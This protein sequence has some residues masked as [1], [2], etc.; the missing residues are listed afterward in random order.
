MK[1]SKGFFGRS[2]KSL[3][4]TLLVLLIVLILGI[5]LGVK[6]GDMSLRDFADRWSGSVKEHKFSFVGNYFKGKK[7]DPK[8]IFLI[9]KKE[10]WSKIE[11][12][13]TIAM[14]VG[15]KWRED[16]RNPGYAKGVLKYEGKEN[17]IKVSLKGGQQDHWG[18][19]DKWSL[20][21]K[22]KEKY[23]F[24]GMKNFS[25]QDLR[26]RSYLNGWLFN[27]LLG[28]LGLIKL[29]FD[30]IEVQING[31]NL[32]IY[33][34]EENMGSNLIEFN[35]LPAGPIVNFNTDMMFGKGSVS[36][37]HYSQS[38]NIDLYESKTVINYE[39]QLMLFNK[40]KTLL[41][42]FRKG[43]F[44]ASQVFD[45]DKMAN[46]YALCDLMGYHH[47]LA[48]YNCKFYFNPVTSRLEPIG[49]DNQDIL[50]LSDSEIVGAGK[51]VGDSGSWIGF[52]QQMLK[53]P[54]F[55]KAYV[56]SLN[57]ISK[58]EFLDS[59]YDLIAEEMEAKMMIIH[60]GYPEYHFDKGMI[61]YDNQKVIRQFINPQNAI[62]AYF[63][64]NGIFNDTIFLDIAN[65]SKMPL[66]IE[67]VTNGSIDYLPVKGYLMQP[68][69]KHAYNEYALPFVSSSI[70]NSKNIKV[71]KLK[72]Y[73]H[74]LGSE[75]INQVEVY[76]WKNRNQEY[77]ENDA[78][79]SKG[80]TQEFKFIQ[81]DEENKVFVINKGSHFI[82]SELIFPKGYQV[83]VEKGVNMNLRNHAKIISYSPVL[84][85]GNEEDPI[86]FYSSDS[87]GQG[88]VVYHC[89]EASEFSYVNF[90]NLSN[91][92]QPGWNLSG[93]VNFYESSIKM[94]HCIFKNNRNGDDLLNI[95]RSEFLISNCLFEKANSDA[96]S[97]YFSKGDINN[98]EFSDIKNDAIEVI[99]SDVTLN[100]L[101]LERIGDIA[102]N[103]G[104]KSII[105][106]S[107]VS[108]TNCDIGIASKDLSEVFIKRSNLN[109][110]RIGLVSLQ[111]QP[112]YGPAKIKARNISFDKKVKTPFLVEKGSA[113]SIDGTEQKSSK[114][115]IKKAIGKALN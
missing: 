65:V 93:V 81:V 88:I 66:I 29:R 85:I 101:I 39:N 2:K 68:A 21:I 106:A 79:R 84:L 59:F 76:P 22:M 58:G 64:S 24:S 51:F 109:L 11:N 14:E 73:Y 61:L 62:K 36:T 108:I 34:I 56:R 37:L 3:A 107:E 96:L 4:L 112:E 77:I 97:S 69:T 99:G 50:P 26:T 27:E 45:V 20:K 6:L 52:Q 53:D 1:E 41:E 12:Q 86:T 113:I 94:D 7:A 47:G 102:I 32:G 44:T 115:D 54:L 67:K 30:F 55:F 5:V 40:A 16:A 100:N 80:N 31:E 70:D 110:T 46:Y 89:K 78:T 114:K 18:R 48:L 90:E 74:V 104:S 10:E 83:I 92:D 98:S 8:K 60:S 91:L 72:V 19:A 43:E 111:T 23:A 13:R 75:F 28:H 57:E 103:V 33:A 49:Y 15:N 35:N 95:I 105:N 25:I 17:K 63:N 82:D 42:G 38:S 71:K 87:T 9:I